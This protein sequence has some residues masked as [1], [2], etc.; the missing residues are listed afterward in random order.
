MKIYLFGSNGMLGT[1]VNN[2]LA[3]RFTI[4][5]LNRNNYDLSKLNINSLEEL[6]L[7]QS[8]EKDDIIIN[9]AGVIPQ[10]SKQR[11]LN[12]K[13]YFTINS[14]FPVILSQLC[15]KY[16][17]KMIHITTDCVFSGKDGLYNELSIQDETNDYG[18]SKSLGE[19][20]KATIIRTSI[21]GEELTNKRSLLEWVKSNEDK[22]ING[23]INHFWNGV[24]CLELSKIICKII[25][26]NLYWEGVRHIFSPRSVSKFELVSM[27]NEIYKLNIKINPFDTEKVD[28]TL[29]TIHETN[30][31]FN[32]PDLKEQ[33]KNL[34]PLM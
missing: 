25:Q 4:V 15:N 12:S 1:Y 34:T 9:C 24:T 14:L 29:T 8:L 3:Q 13:L 22:E 5:S 18:M 32:I 27:I 23:Y 26:D 30:N 20:S 16:G 11:S 17:V 6:L 7:N 10:A 28:K 19:L 31:L 21:I 33:I 2:Y